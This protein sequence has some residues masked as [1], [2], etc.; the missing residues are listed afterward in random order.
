MARY[1]DTMAAIKQ[2]NEATQPQQ[3]TSPSGNGDDAALLA[4]MA[5]RAWGNAQAQAAQNTSNYLAAHQSYSTHCYMIG[6]NVD[7]T[8]Y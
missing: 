7:C 8:T 6:N 1:N 5:L 3:P 4:A 2:Q